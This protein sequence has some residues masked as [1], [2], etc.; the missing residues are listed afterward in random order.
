MNSKHIGGDYNFAW[1]NAEIAVM[2]AEG[3]C[4]IIFRKEIAIPKIR[5]KK[6][7]SL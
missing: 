1:P 4:D 3:A 5:R 2:G 7:Q 6:E